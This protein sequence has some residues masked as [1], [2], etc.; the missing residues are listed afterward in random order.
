MVDK[1]VYFTVPSG[2]AP[3]MPVT[4][5]T[6]LCEVSLCSEGAYDLY[7]GIAQ[8]D[9]HK[10]FTTAKVEGF[11]L[12]GK[13]DRPISIPYKEELYAGEKKYFLKN[14]D[15]LLAEFTWRTAFGAER[16]I[17]L[18][19]FGLPMYIADHFEFWVMNRRP[20]NYRKNIS[21]TLAALG[22]D[23]T[24]RILDVSMGLSLNDCLWV[25]QNPDLSWDTVNLFDNPFDETV[26]KMAFTGEGVGFRFGS[27]SPEF[28]TDG[29]LSKCWVREESGIFLKKTETGRALT[30]YAEVLADQLLEY[31]HIPHAHYTMGSYH[32]HL[33][34]SSKLITSQEIMLV[35]SNVYFDFETVGQLLE[36]LQANGLLQEYADMLLADFLMQNQDRHPGNIG[37]L[38]DSE[39]FVLKG[40]APLYDNGQS[41]FFSDKP[42]LY[43]SWEEV[44]HTL[45]QISN[46]PDVNL[47][48]FY[49]DTS[50]VKG[51]DS[52]YI[53]QA[54]GV[55]ADSE[56]KLKMGSN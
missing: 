47:S 14:K 11:F 45:L 7:Q 26:A 20:P 4:I 10:K 27:P 2:E 44:L 16:P 49:F 8:V 24:K 39:S 42:A 38:L 31:L 9:T 3:S 50:K 55:L 36:L 30:L 35:H 40:L 46:H 5:C 37:V 15:R 21:E 43:G 25:S 13:V 32:N 17:L 19:D 18:R 1:L 12:V 53:D 28:D 6:G 29:V 22:L 34:C 52:T 23:T 41:F 56:K 51:L 33:C 54:Y 48:K